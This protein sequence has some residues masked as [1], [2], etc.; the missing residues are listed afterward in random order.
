M[1][2][3]ATIKAVPQHIPNDVVNVH[4]E[5]DYEGT[6]RPTDVHI[7]IRELSSFRG[8]RWKKVY[9]VPSIPAA[10]AFPIKANFA[11][12]SKAATYDIR[13]QF[14]LNDKP[15]K[16]GKRTGQFFVDP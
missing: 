9:E 12:P 2:S 15:L 7:Y 3:Q 10:M 4:F 6:E 13:V 1:T 14:T 16:D 8:G 11:K 5:A